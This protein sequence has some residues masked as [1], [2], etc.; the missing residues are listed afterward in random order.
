MECDNKPKHDTETQLLGLVPEYLLTGQCSRPSAKEGHQVEGLFWHT[1]FGGSG[2]SFVDPVGNEG[3]ET[4][5]ADDN[6]V[7]NENVLHDVQC[8]PYKYLLPRFLTVLRD[9]VLIPFLIF[10]DELFYR[11]AL[12]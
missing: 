10:W 4:H 3:D 6:D 9:S 12:G 8:P 2:T 7:G 1:T 5:D 11:F